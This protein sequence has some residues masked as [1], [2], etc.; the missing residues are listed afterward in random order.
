[1]STVETSALS[2]LWDADVL[3]GGHDH[4]ASSSSFLLLPSAEH[5][6]LVVPT[7]P[8]QAAGVILK[9]LRD[10]SSF[11][12]R[13][14]TAAVRAALASGIG[15][16]HLPDPDILAVAINQLPGA[17]YVYGVHLGPPRANRKPV[18]VLA[19]EQGELV[20][21]VKWGID[22]LT[23]RLVRNEAD[24]LPSVADLTSVRVPRLL[25][26]G[27][28]ESHPYVIQT[29]VP[30]QGPSPGDAAAVVAAQV[31][32]AS[33]GLASID[34][35]EALE[36]VAQQWRQRVATASQAQ[37]DVAAFAGLAMLWVE[38]ASSESL[39]WGS[40]HGDWRRTNM[41]VTASGCSIWDWERFAT[42]VPLGYDALHLFLTS[43]AASVH[44]LNSLPSDLFDN[45]ARLLRPFGIRDRVLAELT[46]AG[47]LLELAGRYL[48]DNQSQ[49]GAR[50]GSVAVWLLPF[51]STQ[52]A[53]NG[54]CHS[55]RGVG[56][57]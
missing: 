21:F 52:L 28:H 44:E 12:A 24:A 4:T 43:H 39:Q 45:A 5:P 7:R 11:S 22:P 32:V 50:L 36:A 14:R 35:R 6:R 38:Q 9:A 54:S 1:M 26:V 17:E 40:W 49:A 16:V 30:T 53:Q 34:H 19:T 31:E 27:E 10:R 56:E 48:D 47:Y 25:A 42:G 13:A 2:Q 57:L 29:P 37:E 8:H 41:A 51:L 3:R 20:A 55:D 18:L 46:A 23:D 33:V 15:A